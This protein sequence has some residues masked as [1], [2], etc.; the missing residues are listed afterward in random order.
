MPNIDDL[1]NYVLIGAGVFLGY[2]YLTSGKAQKK[3][4]NIS[5]EFKSCKYLNTRTEQSF[6]R[7]LVNSL[8]HHLELN[9]KVR[10]ADLC[11]PVDNKNF[12]SLNKVTSKHVDYA[13]V[14]R[15]T[16]QIVFAIE[17]D[18]KSHSSARAKKQ[19]HEKNYAMDSAGIPLHRVKTGTNYQSAI[20][21]I[22]SRHI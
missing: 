10:L 20:N 7:V 16:S 17:L 4:G 18:D 2:M 1:L 19:D 15:E 21:Q 13:V 9:S 12:T 5:G 3:K 11:R 22:L 14:V 8:P 6:K